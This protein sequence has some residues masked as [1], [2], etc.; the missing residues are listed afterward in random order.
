MF[1]GAF[2][3][4]IWVTLAVA[5]QKTISITNSSPP[6]VEQKL[7]E[8]HVGLTAPELIIALKNS[9]AEVR[10]LAAS[11]LVDLHAQDAR[12]AIVEA[13]TTEQSP[14]VRVEF[15]FALL[16]F[17]D[18]EGEADLRKFCNQG[19]IPG[20]LR[21]RSASYLLS[22]KKSGCL[23]SVLGMVRRNADSDTRAQALTMLPG[24][25][26]VSPRSDI[27]L[28]EAAIASLADPTPSVRIA[29][30]YALAQLGSRSDAHYLN[31]VIAKEQDGTVRS[32]MESA[33]EQLESNKKR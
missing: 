1:Y 18:A 9:E 25:R 11:A 16:R 12:P 6:T 23:N 5:Q 7:Q 22:Q 29:A 17:G 28:R 32:A 33:L 30:I 15:A 24:Y 8:R 27:K 19:D 4:L 21:L 10:S 20:Y 14:V 13:A 26:N 31:S 3:I 2:I